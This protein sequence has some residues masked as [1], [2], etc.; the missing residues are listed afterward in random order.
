MPAPSVTA[1]SETVYDRKTELKAF[2]EAKA[3]VKGIVD[4][5]VSKVPRIFINHQ[6][7]NR[8]KPCTGQKPQLSVPVIDLGGI[9][10]DGEK[11]KKVVKKIGD[12]CQNWGFFQIVNHG[13]SQSMMDDV[14][15]GV[16]KFNELDTDTKKKYYTRDYSNKFVFNSN[17]Y[18]YEGPVT[19]WRDTI[20]FSMAPKL[21]DSDALPSVCRDV[22]IEYSKHVMKLGLTLFE[23][24]SEA[25]GLSPNHLKEMDCA[26]QLMLLGHY[27]PACPEPDVA[28]GF[29][30]HADNDFLTV[31]IQDQV[32][33]LQVL[34]E[35]QW[36]DVPHVPGAL[37]INTGDFLQLVSNDKFK[38]VY[39]RVQAHSVGPRVSMAAFFRSEWN[40]M[41]L[42]GPIKE[43]LSEKN[44]PIYGETTSKDYLKY[45]YTQGQDGN[46]AL[47][48]YKLNNLL[49]GN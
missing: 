7:Y 24:A 32:G 40:N 36:V 10:Q 5:G 47:E 41:R 20:M 38:S 35:D 12:A 8:P 13:I 1:E 3:G 19:N 6:E 4:A 30:K 31:L 33:G 34:H 22:M 9:E 48:H 25:L 37:V 18:L 14:L 23:L 49:K 21:P 16:R 15:D 26:E 39:H 42:Y 27:Y 17:F 44:P 45:Y 28:I 46:L 2:D 29:G 43:L 11:R